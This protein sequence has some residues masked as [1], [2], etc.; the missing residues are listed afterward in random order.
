MEYNR[1]QCTIIF[2]QAS[3]NCENT[4]LVHK[5]IHCGP[6]EKM[7]V[8]NQL[9][10]K[11]I[12]SSTVQTLRHSI[13]QAFKCKRIKVTAKIILVLQITCGNLLEKLTN[14][15]SNR[16]LHLNSIGCS[17]SKVQGV[18]LG[19]NSESSLHFSTLIAGRQLQ[20]T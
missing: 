5:D 4:D 6:F 2:C 10:I 14:T 19:N 18:L 15:L 8:R 3:L 17:S 11:T 20:L 12:K 13:D 9:C 16:H 7:N 1:R